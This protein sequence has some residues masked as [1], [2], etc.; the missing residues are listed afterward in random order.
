MSLPIKPRLNTRHPDTPPSRV[1]FAYKQ[2]DPRTTWTSQEF[3]KVLSRCE[4]CSE[5]I[6]EAVPITDTRPPRKQCFRCLA[7]W[8]NKVV[9]PM[10]AIRKTK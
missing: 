4:I 3:C 7:E 1:R 6:V 10:L 8:Y 2:W 5:P 9:L